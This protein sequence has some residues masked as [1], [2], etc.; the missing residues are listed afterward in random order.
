MH[1]ENRLKMFNRHYNKVLNFEGSM[2]AMSNWL[3][4]KKICINRNY[5]DSYILSLKI[6]GFAIKIS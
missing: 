5:Y 3:T 2:I 1:T 6:H 4:L